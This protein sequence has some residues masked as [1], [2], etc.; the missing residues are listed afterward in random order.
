MA[1]FRSSCAVLL[2]LWATGP[3]CC[4]Q[5]PSGA[6]TKYGELASV[7]RQ[8]R[9]QDEWKTYLQHAREL[10]QLL[11]SSPTTWLNLARG[12]VHL[13]QTEN[14]LSAMQT[15]ADMQQSADILLT[16]PEF[17]AVRELPNFAV[18][19]DSMR[20]NETPVSTAV[21]A[22]ALVESGLVAE[23]IDYDPRGRR[24]YVSSILKGKI[25]AVDRKGRAVDFVKA[26][27]PWP[28]IAV[29]IDT[30][31]RLLWT[32]E[33]ALQGFASIA[34]SD[35]GKSAVLC[36]DLDK[37]KL[38]V[39]V[40][41]PSGSA[42]GDMVLLPNGDPLLSDGAGG[43][44]YLLHRETRSLERIDAGDFI[45]PQTAALHP[46][47]KHLFV[48]DYLRGIGIFDLS[49]RKVAWMDMQKK[50][51]LNGIDGLYFRR[52]SLVLI[53]NG[54]SP[55]RVVEL[56]LD[57]TLSRVT[58]E[59]V[60]ERA[61]KTLGDPTHGVWVGGEFYYIANSGWDVL[62]DDGTV[63]Q[64]ASFTPVHIMRAHVN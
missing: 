64:G 2:I 63:K 59:Q 28:M 12:R 50:Y 51:A 62:N 36:Y 18:L 19:R 42:L 16:S 31:R 10:Q 58:S 44:L 47:G 29:K 53:Q 13:K 25:L 48:P 11:N 34:K 4:G 38:L 27:D 60:I 15:F 37:G 3:F 61:T 30:R 56:K 14:A 45:S 21:P 1:I 41:V 23:D 9:E 32:T 24:F 35:W 8:A 52:S 40:D 17:A 22:F 54:T 46:D 55:E 6:K 43:G 33:V 49:T 20:A 57:S 7:M 26:P 5:L 39:R